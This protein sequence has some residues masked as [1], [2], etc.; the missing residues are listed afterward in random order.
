MTTAS[1]RLR[2]RVSPGAGRAQIV[3]RHGDAWKVRVTAAPEQ[4]RAN[5]A[6]LR[7]IADALVL[8]RDAVVL[9]SGH[10]GRDKIV[11]LTGLGP[12]LAE[13]RLASASAPDR[14]RKDRRS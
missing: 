3:G 4:G 14:G 1:T 8:P 11:E 9:V 13:R 12:A 6:V 10:G 7:L 2:L 5:E